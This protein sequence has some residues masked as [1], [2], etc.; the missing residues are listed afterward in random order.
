MRLLL[1]THVFL[2][3][4]EQPDL[5]TDPLRRA[6]ANSSNEVFVSAASVWEIGIKRAIGKLRFT[7]GIVSTIAAHRFE[8]LPISGEH[9]EHAGELP[10]HHSDPFDRVLVA[11]A[12]LERMIFGTQ[13]AKIRPYAVPVLG[14]TE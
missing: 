12:V 2:W 10:R 1:D 5:I 7:H 9:A 4:N 8:L 13:D 14:L 3:W 6:M 11:Q